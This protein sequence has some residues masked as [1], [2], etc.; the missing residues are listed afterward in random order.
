MK[1]DDVL[2]YVHNDGRDSVAKPF[3]NYQPA[4]GMTRHCN[5]A[6][7]G[8]NLVDVRNREVGMY[9]GIDGPPAEYETYFVWLR[10]TS[11]VWIPA[12]RLHPS[13]RVDKRTQLR[14]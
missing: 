13:R 2:R 8:L 12:L 14:G 1:W 9:Y 5:Y 3:P 4:G 7:S 11:Q 6:T 10:G